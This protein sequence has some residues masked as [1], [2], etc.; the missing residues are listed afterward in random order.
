[1]PVYVYVC[2]KCGEVIERIKSLSEINSQE[3]CPKCGEEMQRKPTC[4]IFKME[5]ATPKFH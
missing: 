5:G 1:M 4:G 2:P 3:T